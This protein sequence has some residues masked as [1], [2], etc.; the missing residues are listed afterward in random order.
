MLLQISCQNIFKDKR[1]KFA[2]AKKLS[3]YNFRRLVGVKRSTFDLMV[4]ALKKLWKTKRRRGGP[5]PRL[6]LDDQILLTLSYWRNY[7]TY[8]ETGSKFGVSES[9]AFIYCRWVE[10]NLI[11]QKIF[12]LPGKK[13]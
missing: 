1:M 11:K 13:N 7:G 9:S 4:E 8:F 2:A 5:S 10:N 3:D 12:H 6:S